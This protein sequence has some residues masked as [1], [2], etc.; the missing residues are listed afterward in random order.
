MTYAEALAKSSPQADVVKIPVVL[1]SGHAA[2]AA[3][4]IGPA[5]QLF[6]VTEEAEMLAVPDDSGVAQELLRKALLVGSPRP[7]IQVN[8]DSTSVSTEEFEG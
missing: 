6:S 2:E 1:D 3:F 7:M 8:G 4:L 5:S